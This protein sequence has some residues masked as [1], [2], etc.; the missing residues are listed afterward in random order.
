MKPKEKAEE[1]LAEHKCKFYVN[2]DWSYLRCNCGKRIKPKRD[3][4]QD[5][6]A[7]YKLKRSHHKI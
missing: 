6:R 5:T 7:H 3:D 1:V 2:A 4:Q